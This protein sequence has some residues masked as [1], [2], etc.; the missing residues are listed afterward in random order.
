MRGLYG[1]HHGAIVAGS[2]GIVNYFSPFVAAFHAAGCIYWY[3][4]R[5]FDQYEQRSKDNR[6]RPV[7]WRLQW[8]ELIEWWDFITPSLVSISYLYF[9]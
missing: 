5:E 3:V 9:I 1:I 7:E 4:S 6:Q 2:L 8:H